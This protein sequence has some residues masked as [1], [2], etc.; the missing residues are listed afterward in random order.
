MLES[1]EEG[2][3]EG[4]YPLYFSTWHRPGDWRKRRSCPYSRS[5]TVP[6]PSYLLT[7]RRK[8]KPIIFFSVFSLVRPGSR[9][10]GRDVTYIYMLTSTQSVVHWNPL[11]IISLRHH[12][13][14]VLSSRFL[15]FT[16]TK[17]IMSRPLSYSRLKDNTYFLFGDKEHL[18]RVTKQLRQQQMWT[19]NLYIENFV[20]SKST[21]DETPPDQKKKFT[22]TKSYKLIFFSNIIL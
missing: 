2:T 16:E 11:F 22:Y 8:L 21:T 6:P 4:C 15:S 12:T 3:S 9:K 20:L 10:E 18:W 14:L 19:I 7:I 1:E 13:R 17:I 5:K